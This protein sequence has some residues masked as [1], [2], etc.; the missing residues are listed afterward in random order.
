MA[1][2]Y[3]LSKKKLDVG[4]GCRETHKASNDA[5]SPTTQVI[6]YSVITRAFIEH[7]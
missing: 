4:I 6:I 2:Q 7:Y 3:A 1:Y 5:L